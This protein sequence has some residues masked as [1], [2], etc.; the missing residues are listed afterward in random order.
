MKVSVDKIKEFFSPLV[1][2]RLYIVSGALMTVLVAFGVL[3]D[4]QS[5]QWG[6]LVV[7]IVTAIFAIVNSESNWRTAL[8]YVAGAAAVLLQGYGILGQERWA[9]ILGL[10]AALLGSSTAAAKA[11]TTGRH[12]LESQQD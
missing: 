3:T 10:V 7:A 12:S 11:P 9:A 1:R 5:A 8:Y 4:Q 2:E 6:A